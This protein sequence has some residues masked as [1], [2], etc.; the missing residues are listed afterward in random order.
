[1]ECLGV[2]ACKERSRPMSITK[3]KWLAGGGLALLVGAGSLVAIAARYAKR[4]EPYVREQAI[5]YLQK[6]FDS[7]VELGALHVRFPNV[8]PIRIV[9]ARVRGTTAL[10]EGERLLLRHRGRRDIPPVFAIQKFSFQIDIGTLFDPS[11]VIPRVSLEGME[12]TI[13]PP[14][15]RPA[16]RGSSRPDENLS[17]T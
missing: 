11:I 17:N 7:D 5:N 2:S 14:G 8:S 13:P 15:Q 6:R 12:I 1:M 3:K 16:I 4:F 10:V 9:L